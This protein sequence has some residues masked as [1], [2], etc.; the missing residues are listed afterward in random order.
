MGLKDEFRNMVMAL[1]TKFTPPPIADIFFPPFLRGG[2]P[3]DA[4][5]MAISLEGGA[6]G[7]S[8]VLLPEE[9]MEA[10]SALKPLDFV[11][12]SPRE[13]ALEFGNEDPVKEMISLAAINA[14]CQHVMRETHFPIDD[15]TDSLGLLSVSP[16]DR[17]GMVGLFYGLVKKIKKAGAELVVIEKNERLIDKFPDLPI[18]LDPAKLRTCNKILCTS[19]TI[20]N[21]T[22][23][24]ILAHCSPDA[25]V[26]II[27][28]T[29]GYFPD[30]LFARGVDVVGGRVVRN[31]VR[32]LQT[33]AE[34]K[35]WGDATQRTCFQKE[36]YSSIL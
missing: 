6:A 26:S 5:F 7:I 16:G 11:E 34:R 3:K 13:F 17:I 20:L 29:A 28:P 25:F 21:N 14:I 27:G 4:Q 31:G 19:M 18:T 8:F 1:T 23:D 33:L 30:P 15:A 22:L 12:K 35:R 10:Y 32:F 36:T 2:Q 9:R 24:E